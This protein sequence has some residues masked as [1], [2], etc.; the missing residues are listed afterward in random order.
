M[1]KKTHFA[2]PVAEADIAG[3]C[4]THDLK[5]Y[6]GGVECPA[7]V[8]EVKL[9]AA[10]D[11]LREANGLVQDFLDDVGTL[12][13]RPYKAWEWFK[14][15]GIYFGKLAAKFDTVLARLGGDK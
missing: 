13:K 2:R 4:F 11:A 15:Y 3:E 14:S 7:C 5:W 8:A 1:T 9:A 12:D 6:S 10:A